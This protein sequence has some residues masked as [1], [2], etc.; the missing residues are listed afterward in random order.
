LAI[1]AY[2]F[3]MAQRLKADSDGRENQKTF[4]L[5]RRL[6][7]PRI[8][9][10]GI[11]QGAQRPVADSITTLRLRL[12]VALTRALGHCSHCSWVNLRLHL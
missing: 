12:G 1:A 6:A 11:G 2:G 9:F 4:P 5:A 8:T 10:L 3:L 7:F